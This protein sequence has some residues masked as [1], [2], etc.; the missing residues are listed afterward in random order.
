V[1]LL[2]KVLKYLM[3]FSF[4]IRA[5]IIYR[6]FSTKGD[7]FRSFFTISGIFSMV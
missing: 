4:S 2:C 1:V 5:F 7:S 3:S 6:H